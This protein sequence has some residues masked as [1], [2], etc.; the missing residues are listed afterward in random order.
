MS[1]LS[2]R[3]INPYASLCHDDVQRIRQSYPIIAAK[4]SQFARRFYKILFDYSP[5]LKPMFQADMSVQE[6][7]FSMLMSQ[8]V[9]HLDNLDALER[10]LDELAN[11]H[12]NAGVKKEQ[13]VLVRSA[14]LL[15]IEYTLAPEFNQAIWQSWANYYD[16]IANKMIHAMDTL[17]SV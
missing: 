9:A 17:P 3:D 15:T 16:V 10:R 1:S 11:K 13:F 7:H 14:F 5:F 2:K 8:S 4:E 12:S 6:K